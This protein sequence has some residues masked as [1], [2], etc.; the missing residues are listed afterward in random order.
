MGSRIIASSKKNARHTM[1]ADLGMGSG[2]KRVPGCCRAPGKLPN[3]PSRISIPKWSRA[4]RYPL[5]PPDRILQPEFLLTRASS[6]RASARS[7][8]PLRNA[9][10]L[11]E[12]HL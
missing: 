11:H 7:S 6:R 4:S 5:I 2:S 9:R 3:P 1:D 8:E 10:R 12:T